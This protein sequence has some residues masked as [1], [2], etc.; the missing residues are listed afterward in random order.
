MAQTG[1]GLIMVKYGRNGGR[2]EQ[3]RTKR[4]AWEGAW[5]RS[6]KEY[7]DSR[8]GRNRQNVAGNCVHHGLC[9]ILRDMPY[10]LRKQRDGRAGL[11]DTCERGDT[12]HKR[13]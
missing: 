12:G 11:G 1:S 7:G 9:H 4:Q 6:R 8:E 5:G 3:E 13:D 10:S 2:D